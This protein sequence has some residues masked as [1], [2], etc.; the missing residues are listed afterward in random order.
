MTLRANIADGS[1]PAGS[2]IS[3]GT[4]DGVHLGHRHL[5]GTLTEIA[6]QEGLTPVALSFKNSPRS[7]LNPAA[8]LSYIT[9]LGTRLSLLHQL[10]IGLVVP[11]EFT[12]E[13]S[14]LSATQFVGALRRELAMKGLVVGP[15]F[16]LGHRRQG[17]VATL[18]EMGETAGFWVKTVD[19]FVQDGA[20][21]KSSGIREL[22]SQGRVEQVRRMLDR[23]FSLAGEV[24]SGDRRGRDLGF[25][26]ANLSPQPTM[27]VPGDGIYATWATVDGVRH[28]GATSIGVRPTFGGGGARRIETYLLEFSGDLYGKR[29]TLEFAQ[30]L[31]GELAFS[32]VDALVQQMKQDV[33]QSRAVLSGERQ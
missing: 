2:A 31:R 5:L 13:L 18:K 20:P 3:I 15:D 33:E 14:Q 21:V 30:R 17:D 23:P 12:R 1:V 8:Q 7:V 27:A 4:F 24:E 29:M 9:D 32:S 19:N 26:T 25:P 16:A 22:L 28:Q 10:G 6:R 11:V